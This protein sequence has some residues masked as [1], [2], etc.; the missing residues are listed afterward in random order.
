[1]QL[2]LLK[3]SSRR[4]RGPKSRN[5]AFFEPVLEEARPGQTQGAP[6]TLYRQAEIH[7]P[8]AQAKVILAA[9]SAFIAL[10]SLLMAGP[11]HGPCETPS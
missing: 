10:H 2:F 4:P 8:E 3:P 11:D 6:L 9:D 7:K 5:I 1:M